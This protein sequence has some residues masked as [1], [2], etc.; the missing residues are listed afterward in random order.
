MSIQLLARVNIAIE[1]T[2]VLVKFN[3]SI[4]LLI[5]VSSL[6]FLTACSVLTQGSPSHNANVYSKIMPLLPVPN[7]LQN[8]V[9]LEKFTFSFDKSTSSKSSSQNSAKASTDKVSG[10]A[11]QSMLLQT[12]LSKQGINIAA[13]SFD[14]IPLAQASWHGGSQAVKS[15][16]TVAKHFD[17]KQVL[18]DLQI[19]NWPINS[20]APA[21]AKNMSVDEKIVPNS[22]TGIKIKTRRF[23]H[24]GEVIIIIRYQA[25]EISFEQ[26][27]AGYSLLITRLTDNDLTAVLKP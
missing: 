24:Q 22:I 23:Y 15:E 14:G 10:Y 20:I 2:K 21:L 7:A 1:G 25:K 17:A 26:L 18:H 8:R 19:V 13:M 11:K 3:E 16:L 12:E 9:W 5:M 4:K 27:S 6:I